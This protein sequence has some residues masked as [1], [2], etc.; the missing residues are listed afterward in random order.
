MNVDHHELRSAFERFLAARRV[1]RQ[2]YRGFVASHGPAESRPMLDRVASEQA[3]NHPA[4]SAEL[5]ELRDENVGLRRSLTLL[6]AHSLSLQDQ[7]DTLLEKVRMSGKCDAVAS[8]MREGRRAVE[9]P[10]SPGGHHD[11]DG[12]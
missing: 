11:C 9:Y 8:R 3:G 10:G 7:L 4:M 2:A 12:R 1:L 5:E 6:H